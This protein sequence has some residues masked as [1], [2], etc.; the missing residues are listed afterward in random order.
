M[1]LTLI[2]CLM[3]LIGLFGCRST[4]D[5]ERERVCEE[6]IH[7]IKENIYL[8][9][10]TVGPIY[11]FRDSTSVDVE[12]IRENSFL[13]QECFLGWRKTKVRELLGRPSVDYNYL[14]NKNVWRFFLLSKGCGQLEKECV[15][16]EFRFDNKDKV[17]Y[18]EENTLNK[19]L[20]YWH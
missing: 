12:L 4:K 14:N 19:K 9:D 13:L 11:Y 1:K 10:S 17:R 5:K 7:F 18:F 2:V 20:H 16:W 3:G 6:R 15:Y 8:K